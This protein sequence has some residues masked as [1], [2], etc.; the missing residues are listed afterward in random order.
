MFNGSTKDT[1]SPANF[2]SFKSAS[3]FSPAVSTLAL[4]VTFVPSCLRVKV[5]FCK[6]RCVSKSAFQVPVTSAARAESGR[7]ARVKRMIGI[8]IF[9]CAA[10]QLLN[11]APIHGGQMEFEDNW[12]NII[13]CF[14]ISDL[15]NDC[16]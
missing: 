12:D 15:V 2:P 16:A 11:Q 5:Y 13:G 14:S 10:D 3:R 8:F 4:P 7:A 6:P 9:I 1:V